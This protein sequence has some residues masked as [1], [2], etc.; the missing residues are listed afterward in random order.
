MKIETLKD[1]KQVLQLC[2]R[3][4]VTEIKIDGIEAKISLQSKPIKRTSIDL[5]LPPEAYIPVPQYQAPIASE[6]TIDT[7]IDMPDQLSEE[8]LMYYS[9]T[10]ETN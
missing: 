5:D 7:D 4:G 6:A 10:G 2:Q 9:A 1:F 8:Q 3:M